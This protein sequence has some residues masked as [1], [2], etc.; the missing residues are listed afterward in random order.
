MMKKLLLLAVLAAASSVA[1][2]QSLA[3]RLQQ[4]LGNSKSSTEQ[5]KPAPA[6]PT[7]QQI[8]DVSWKYQSPS[9]EYRGNDMLLALAVTNLK[10]QF[11]VLY[12]QAG[13]VP[14]KDVLVLGGRGRFSADMARHRIAGNYKYDPRTGAIDLTVASY[15]TMPDANG[16]TVKKEV[17]GHVVRGYITAANG[18]LTLQFDA[19]DTMKVALKVAPSL[20][21][22]QEFSAIATM[23]Q[24]YPGLMLGGNFKR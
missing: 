3:D 20:A 11:S 13:I 18:V 19:G 1:S 17:G 14:G 12:T 7:A 16:N 6:Y 22:N 10:D 21:E 23:L 24:S 8:V 9:I 2:A 5:T 4:F 15:S